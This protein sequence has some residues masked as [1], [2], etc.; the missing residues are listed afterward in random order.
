MRNLGVAVR[1]VTVQAK[2]AT[3]EPI[4]ANTGIEE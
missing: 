4:N 1:A 3:G 2:G